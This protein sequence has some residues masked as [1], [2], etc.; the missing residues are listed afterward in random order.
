MWP[1]RKREDRA[2][3]Q[4]G[5]AWPG[6]A[7]FS[8]VSVSPDTALRLSAVWAC[9]RILSDTIS[10]L[11][12]RT[13]DAD[14]LR[15]VAP[16]SL[17][18]APAAHTKW[19]SWIAQIM[20]STLL[21]GDTYGLIAARAGAGMRPSQIELVHPDRVSATLATDRM[22][23]IYRFDGR[24]II[25]G[26][27]LWRFPG[28]EYPGVPGGLSP[29]A[30]ARETVGLGLATQKYGAEFF[31]AEGRPAGLLFADKK[32]DDTEFD[33]LQKRWNEQHVGKRRTAIVE[34]LKYEA[35]GVPPEKAQFLE[36][37]QFTVQ[38]I[39]MIY[40]VPPEMIAA[41]VAGQSITYSNTETKPLDLLKFG[42]GP[43][44]VRLQ[45]ELDDLLPGSIVGRFDPAGLLRADLKTR[46]DAYQVAIDGGWL[47]IPE[48]RA[49]EE[50]PPVPAGSER[51][52]L[53][54]VS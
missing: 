32:L 15:P 45:A 31:G 10:T 38:E 29:I 46:Y 52:R 4:V 2:V 11:P 41:A 27:E 48:V 23:T 43:W 25:R 40:G 30:Y 50:L 49:L 1:F 47:T 28:Y 34:G 42:V 7:T 14:T 37:R 36:T 54:A 3:W 8:G 24:E 13:F 9:I 21:T 18:V 16:P 44:L 12:Y 17:L 22:T 51:P 39:A 33:T 35:V 26:E 5:D 19:H 53:E 20:R 6:P